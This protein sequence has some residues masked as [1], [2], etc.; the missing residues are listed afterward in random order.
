[1]KTYKGTNLDLEFYQGRST[2][3]YEIEVLNDDGTAFDLTVYSSIVAKVYYRKHGEEI[4]TPTVTNSANVLMLDLTKTQTTALQA[5]EYWYEIYG[6]ISSE[7]ELICYGF[8][9]G[10]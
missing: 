9:K 8:L 4:L 5:R 3:D 6:V 7:N 1:M 2:I 10:V